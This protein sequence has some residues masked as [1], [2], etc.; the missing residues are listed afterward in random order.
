MALVMDFRCKAQLHKEENKMEYTQRQI[1][2]LLSTINAGN[3]LRSNKPY[4]TA[5]KGL[6]RSMSAYGILGFVR[7][8]EGY[9]IVLI[10]ER[11]KQAQIGAHT[12]YK[13]EDTKLVPIPNESIVQKIQHPDESRQEKKYYCGE[14]VMVAVIVL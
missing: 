4:E 9:Y 1:K 14:R 6:S 11:R 2:E 8:L 12:I 10:T 3:T 7:F 5:S 13:V